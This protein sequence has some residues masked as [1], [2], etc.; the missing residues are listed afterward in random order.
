MKDLGETLGW[1]WG[2]RVSLEDWEGFHF[3]RSIWKE[4]RGSY[5]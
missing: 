3:L 4:R 1:S 5:F 2:S